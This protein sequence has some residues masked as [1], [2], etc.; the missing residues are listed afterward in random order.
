MSVRL[1][2]L[3]L[4]EQCMFLMLMT[5][6]LMW[7]IIITHNSLS[8]TSSNLKCPCLLQA[9]GVIHS[10]KG[11]VSV[12]FCFQLSPRQ[13]GVGSSLLF[14]DLNSSIKYKGGTKINS[15]S[16]Q[17]NEFDTCAVGTSNSPLDFEA[18]SSACF[19]CSHLNQG[20][21]YTWQFILR[22]NRQPAGS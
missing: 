19:Y 14:S 17:W 8:A 20:L 5:R 12:G 4:I 9:R 6:A 22:Q 18:N 10:M 15:H 21:I 7:N 1:K 16:A 13:P 2:Q 11:L 3:H